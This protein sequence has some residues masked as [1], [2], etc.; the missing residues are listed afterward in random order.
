MID[1]IVVDIP[2]KPDQ[3]PIAENKLSTSF[4]IENETGIVHHTMVSGMLS[5]SWDYN[6]RAMVK[7]TKYQ[8]MKDEETVFRIYKKNLFGDTIGVHEIKNFVGR[9]I[10]IACDPYLRI[11]FSLPKW[12]YGV[13]F[14]TTSL[15]HDFLALTCFRSWLSSVLGFELPFFDKWTLRRLDLGYNLYGFND[16]YLIQYI[17]LLSSLDY[18]KRGKPVKY[19][20][21]L[22]WKG[23]TTT[24]KLYIK[25]ADFRKHDSKRL[26]KNNDKETIINIKNL[27]NG[28]LRFETEFHK[29]KLNT[30][31]I[32]TIAD[33][34]VYDWEKE[35]IK[36]KELI[37]GKAKIGKITRHKEVSEHLRH[38]DLTGYEI[39]YGNLM[40]IWTSIVVEGEKKTRQIFGKMKTWR[41]KRVFNDF[42]ISL[43]GDLRIRKIPRELNKMD[44][45][46]MKPVSNNVFVE[47][48]KI[49]KMNQKNIFWYLDNAA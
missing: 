30:L 46:H 49:V 48:S 17:D 2:L 1:T 36:E 8:Y 38:V 33:M 10:Q 15:G 25:S 40:A 21:G 11:E 47:Y 42:E 23:A 31:K 9:T 19:K 28:I 35:M 24:T 12:A 6:I 32:E 4:K 29:R 22:Y 5:G 44:I 39:S 43:A 7:D 41:A 14:L 34:I 27:T 20:T 18:P 3:I 45:F 13:N 26:Q 37:F 16:F